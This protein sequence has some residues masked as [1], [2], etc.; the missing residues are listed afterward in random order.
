[1]FPYEPSNKRH[2]QKGHHGK[3]LFVG[4]YRGSESFQGFLKVVRN[5]FRNHSIISRM[6]VS[7]LFPYK[8]SKGSPPKKATHTAPFKGGPGDP[9]GSSRRLRGPP[10]QPPRQQRAQRAG[11]REGGGDARGAA[12]RLPVGVLGKPSQTRVGWGGVGWGGVGRGGA[13]RGGVGW[14]GCGSL[15]F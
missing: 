9:P 3:L 13:G 10:V 6:M 2:P 15:S 4:I 8:P 12:H 11:D 14:G 5:G 1:M 7:F